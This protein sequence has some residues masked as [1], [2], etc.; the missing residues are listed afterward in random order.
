MNI[1]Q[2][3]LNP[4]TLS[5]VGAGINSAQ[6]AIVNIGGVSQRCVVKMVGDREIAAECFCALLGDALSLQT[7]TPVIITHPGDNSL[8]FG[9]RDAAYPSLSA[10][11]NIG[12]TVNQ[13]QLVALAQILATWAQVGHV[14]SFDELVANGDRNPGNVLWNGTVFTIIDH[15]RSLGNMPKLSN[16]LALFATANFH[17]QLVASVSSAVTGSAMAQQAFLAA[18]QSVWDMIRSEFL[19]APHAIGQHYGACESLAKQLVTSLPSH[20]ANAMSPLLQGAHL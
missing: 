12:A 3:L 5:P 20:A 13:H 7:L 19:A 4:F 14:I 1:E 17:S 16:R 8:W 9:A 15:E 18:D 10:R 6:Y 11:L 2:G